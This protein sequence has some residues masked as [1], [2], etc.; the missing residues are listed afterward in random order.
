MLHTPDGFVS[1][2]PV[3]GITQGHAASQDV[4][5][6]AYADCMNSVG[7]SERGRNLM[8]VNPITKQT[9]SVCNTVFIDDLG[10]KATGATLEQ[11]VHACNISLTF[12]TSISTRTV[13][14]KTCRTPRS[15]FGVTALDRVCFRC[16]C[17]MLGMEDRLLNLGTSPAFFGNLFDIRGRSWNMMEHMV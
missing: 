9:I 17:I 13:F 10:A 4:F 2:R 7:T 14:I 15:S 11:V 6:V 12:T 16:V 3:D 1:M 8:A 5:N